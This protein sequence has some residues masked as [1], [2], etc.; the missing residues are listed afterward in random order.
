[1]PAY[2]TASKGLSEAQ[3]EAL[4]RACI[5]AGISRPEAI[6]QALKLFVESQGLKWPE[7]QQ[8][9]GYRHGKPTRCDICDFGVLDGEFCSNEHCAR[10]Y[11][12]ER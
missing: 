9:G 6:D 12:E 7:T 1:M 11:H 2:S 5:L 3:D 10:N 8:H 4:N